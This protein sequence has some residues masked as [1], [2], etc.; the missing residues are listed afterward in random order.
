MEIYEKGV[1]ITIPSLIFYISPSKD[2]LFK[3]FAISASYT[4]YHVGNHS[5]IITY[6]DIKIVL[7]QR[8]YITMS[9][10]ICKK[11]FIKE[12]IQDMINSLITH[13]TEILCD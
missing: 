6:C 11:V 4:E 1:Q 9:G 3:P 5:Y 8:I 10:R 7:T 12:I 2:A 13:I